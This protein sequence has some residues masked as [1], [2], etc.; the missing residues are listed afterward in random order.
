MQLK[1]EVVKGLIA[2]TSEVELL[3]QFS[4]ELGKWGVKHFGYFKLDE[5]NDPV[6]IS[7]YPQKWI[8]EYIAQDYQKV[9]S[10]VLLCKRSVKPFTWEHARK[11]SIHEHSSLFWLRAEQAGLSFG[12]SFPIMLGV[13]EVAGLGLC[14]AYSD[15]QKWLNEYENE[16]TVLSNIFHYKVVQIRSDAKSNLKLYRL[17]NRELE[18]ARLLCLGESF[19]TI[20]EKMN[21][22]ERTV[23]FHAD[24]IK[25]KL[26]V[27]TKEHA[28]A[29]LA[30]LRLVSM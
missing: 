26:S 23:R 20:A 29:K 18:C 28:I 24:R 9:D 8:D 6:V 22:S 1:S 27:E 11:L 5:Y 25:E 17:S 16:M 21:I 2:L 30:S 3:K 19:R 7:N 4:D 10:T 15:E 14:I 13:T 12:V